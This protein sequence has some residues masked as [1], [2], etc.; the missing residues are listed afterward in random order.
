MNDPNRVLKWLALKHVNG[1]GNLLFKR[2]IDT[3][4]SPENVFNAP[5]SQLYRVDGITKE[6]GR[7]I[8][9]HKISEGI[10]KDLEL[11]E[12][13]NI[14][15]LT[16]ADDNYPKLLLQIP[17]PPPVLYVYGTLNP[18]SHHIAI[19]GSRNASQY[20]LKCAYRL[21]TGLVNQ[22]FVIVSGMARGID[23]A[24]HQGAI[25]GKGQTIAVAGC[26]LGIVYPPENKMLFKQIALNGAVISEFPI[27]AKPEAYHF[28]IRNRIISGMSW[29]TIIV[30]AGK[31][32]GSLITARLAL[33]QNR[34]VFAVPGDINSFRSMGT[35]N[36][37]KQGAKLIETIEDILEDLAPIFQFTPE[38]D[39]ESCH[40]KPEKREELLPEEQAVMQL[41]SD[42]PMHIDDIMRTGTIALK[43]LSAILLSLELKGYIDQHPGKLFSK[44]EVF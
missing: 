26:G 12:K 33:E 8:Y 17:D 24:S 22:G 34:Q 14:S 9:H 15:L 31:K 5:E 41:V 18:N 44:R 43:D 23:T 6:L 39:K 36:L 40:V 38:N 16:M 4:G 35:N 27:Q 3:F 37:I 7:R 30:E 29:G 2:L 32:S 19:V 28:P 10:Y 1:I 20:G 13:Y 21:S 25:E 42:T 11:A